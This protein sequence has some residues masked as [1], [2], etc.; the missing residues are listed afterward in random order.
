MY[1]IHADQ[2]GW[3]GGSNVGIAYIPYMERMGKWVSA[4]EALC[5]S[6]TPCLQL[7]KL[8]PSQQATGCAPPG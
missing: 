3:F 4:W 8:P 5:I 1:A 7:R 6:L 2:L